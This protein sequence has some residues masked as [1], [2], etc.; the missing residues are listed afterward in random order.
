MGPFAGLQHA[1]P[2]G[3][4]GARLPVS[5][6]F[7]IHSSV[8]CGD[9]RTVA[10]PPRHAAASVG[11][12]PS[13]PWHLH[14][15]PDL[16]PSPPAMRQCAQSTSTP[17]PIVANNDLQRASDAKNWSSTREK[18]SSRRILCLASPMKTHTGK[19]SKALS[20][21]TNTA[22]LTALV[23]VAFRQQFHLESPRSFSVHNLA[24]STP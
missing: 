1:I 8:G 15:F 2:D 7:R 20:K 4:T 12:V 21:N 10:T 3:S 6:P 24:T 17:A 23:A 22:F 5:H 11:F 14:D 9:G 13:K 19:G 16:S 18:A